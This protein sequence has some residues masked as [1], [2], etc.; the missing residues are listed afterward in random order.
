MIFNVQYGTF[1]N[2]LKKEMQ[3]LYRTGE[4]SINN[5][6]C[7]MTIINYEDTR[8]C[9]IKFDDGTVIKGIQ[10]DSFVKG[11]VKNNNYKSI[12]GV[13]CYGYGKYT[14][15]DKAYVYWFNMLNRCYNPK[16]LK[17]RPTYIQCYVCDEWHNYQ[18]FAKWFEE[19]Y[20]EIEGEEICLDKDILIKGNKMYAPETCIFV[21]A[22]INSIF[23]KGDSV[24]GECCIG[25]SKNDNGEYRVYVSNYGKAKKGLHTYKNEIDAFKEY[26]IE[27]E[28]YI[29]EVADR[30][31]GNIP[32]KLYEALYNYSVE[33]DD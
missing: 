12:Y 9:T 8:H 6:G 18:N 17:T 10:Y 29:K 15:D 33:F 19:N 30:Y 7:G 25:I 32:S 5:Q 3:K 21:S 11:A 26:K 20:Y 4:S 14:S 16:Y 13:G 22:L 31:K 24:R 27:K 1:L 28:K 2:G 23:T